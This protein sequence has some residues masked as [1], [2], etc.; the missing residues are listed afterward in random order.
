[1]MFWKGTA[2]CL[3]VLYSARGRAEV[4]AA[5]PRPDASRAFYEFVSKLTPDDQRMVFSGL[6]A[7]T[8]ERLWHDHLLEMERRHPEL[9]SKQ[10]AIIREAHALI[11]SGVFRQVRVDRQS[12]PDHAIDLQLERLHRRAVEVLGFDLAF[13]ALAQ[14]GY[15]ENM[16]V[17]LPQ[18]DIETAVDA[19]GVAFTKAETDDLP[20]RTCTTW[21]DWCGLM[22]KCEGGG[23]YWSTWGCGTLFA[24]ACVGMCKGYEGCGCPGDP[25]PVP[26]EE[27]PS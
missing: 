6:A 21:D 3:A 25:K 7:E 5:A 1:M 22:A 17:S 8:K 19:Y 20:R 14:L 11:D 10:L 24:R 12:P 13:E 16:H 23:C 9:T 26:V 2:L 4:P 18:T 27:P 15:G